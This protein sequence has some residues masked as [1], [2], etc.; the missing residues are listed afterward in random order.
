MS[1]QTN[2][3]VEIEAYIE[4]ARCTTCNECTNLNKR[5]FAYNEKKQATIKD[6]S[7]GTFAQLVQA[8]EKCPV[9]IIHPGSPRNPD[10]KNLDKWLARAAPFNT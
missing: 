1:T 4:S 6:P 8:A 3:A 7:A 10:E 9:R 5:M 2:S